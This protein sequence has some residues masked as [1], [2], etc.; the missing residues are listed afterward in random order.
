MRVRVRVRARVR[1]RVRANPHQVVAARLRACAAVHEHARHGGHH[2]QVGVVHQRLQLGQR[3]ELPHGR[4]KRRV[5]AQVEQRAAG[6]REDL[7][8]F[9]REQLDQWPDAVQ[10]G[11]LRARQQSRGLHGLGLLGIVPAWRKWQG[12]HH[13]CQVP[14]SAR[15]RHGAMAA[16]RAQERLL[17]RGRALAHLRGSQRT[18]A[19]RPPCPRSCPNEAGRAAAPRVAST[20]TK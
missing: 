18:S 16:R 15:A 5:E 13:G 11:H 10:G 3:A 20:H 7:G 12:W 1:V 17:T 14:L 2:A 19:S 8:V 6:A 4:S 9:G